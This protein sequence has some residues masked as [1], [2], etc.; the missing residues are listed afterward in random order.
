MRV[1]TRVAGAALVAALAATATGCGSPPWL[2]ET[3]ATP[4][5][6]ASAA[7]SPGRTFGDAATAPAVS[8]SPEPVVNDLATG[9]AERELQAGAV[10]A[11]VTYWS[12]LTM[13]RWTPAAVKPVSL[14][15]S[16]TITPDDGQGVYLQ[17]VSMTV[18][19]DAGD[20]LAD[21]ADASTEAPGY[22]VLSPYS[23]SQTFSIGA[24]SESATELT[25]QLRYEFLVQ[26]TPTS[27]EYSK[28][29]AVDTLTIALASAG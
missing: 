21:Q 22:L 3:V 19:P 11:T 9:S 25:V 20:A 12:D 5:A 24:V 29:T 23:Y 6:T 28:Q 27:D 8:E 14:S 17:R 13:D 26:T 15:L 16:T 2:D 10:T 7:P 4:E 18:V 1:T